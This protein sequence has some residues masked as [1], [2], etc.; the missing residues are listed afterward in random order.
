MSRSNLTKRIEEL[1]YE[2]D[3]SS[4]YIHRFILKLHAIGEDPEDYCE[5]RHLKR[6]GDPKGDSVRG[7]QP[8]KLIPVVKGG[9]IPWLKNNGGPWKGKDNVL[10]IL[11]GDYSIGHWDMNGNPIKYARIN[12]EEGIS[13]V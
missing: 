6:H 3:P 1:E 12:G 8:G 4:F 9:M 13:N 2:T 11:T 7:L 10:D 5:F